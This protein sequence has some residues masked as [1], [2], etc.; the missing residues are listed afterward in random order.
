R[1]EARDARKIRAQFRREFFDVG[2]G[3]CEPDLLVVLEPDQAHHAPLQQTR[4]CHGCITSHGVAD[5]YHVLRAQF[6]HD[7]GH[8]LA[9]RFDGPVLPAHRR[10]AVTC[11]IERDH[12][13][14]FRERIDPIFSSTRIEAGFHSNTGASSRAKRASSFRYSSIAAPAAD[15]MPRPHNGSP[16]QYPN[17]AVRTKMPSPARAPIPPTAVPSYSIA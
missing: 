7:C 6:A 12:A 4:G 8:V 15:M 11:E 10:F 5:E 3:A 16:S 13:V 9:V 1:D 17:W 2:I 14:S